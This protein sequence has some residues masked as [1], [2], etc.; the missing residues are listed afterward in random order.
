V[1]RRSK[2]KSPMTRT[3]V[4]DS[5]ALSPDATAFGLSMIETRPWAGGVKQ[6]QQFRDKLDAYLA[7]ILDGQLARE[8]PD[9]VGKR[10]V[11]ILHCVEEPPEEIH[12]GV[13]RILRDHD[14][15]FEVWPLE[16]T[17]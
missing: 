3:D 14:I 12:E 2:D 10:R 8:Y 4:V 11:V 6:L 13:E 1:F 9:L 15:E 5:V 7:F 16:R 17:T